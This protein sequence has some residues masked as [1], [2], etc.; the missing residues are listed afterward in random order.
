MN[1]WEA[2]H[3]AIL[4]HFDLELMMAPF[5]PMDEHVIIQLTL[6]RKGEPH[7][8]FSRAIFSMDQVATVSY[9]EEGARAKYLAIR[10]TML[11]EDFDW[12]RYWDNYWEGQTD[13]EVKTFEVLGSGLDNL[14]RSRE[15]M[16]GTN[17]APEE[18]TAE[19][20]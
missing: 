4:G 2:F 6:T 1:E 12:S 13:W 20:E 9:S 14:L 19:P 3:R 8:V 16:Y 10:D 15:V 7:L 5:D 18:G 11:S 17:A